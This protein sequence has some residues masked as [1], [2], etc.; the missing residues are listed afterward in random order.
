MK[1]TIFFFVICFSVLSASAQ[2]FYHGAGLGAVVSKPGVGSI[3]AKVFATLHYYPQVSFFE[4]ETFSVSVGIPFTVGFSGSYNGSVGRRID[5]QKDNTLFG[6]VQI[7]LMLNFNN[8][9]G[10]SKDNEQAYGYFF[11][12][13]FGYHSTG[14]D[15]VLVTDELG[16]EIGTKKIYSKGFAPTANAGAR[17]L[18]GS[19]GR[20]IEIRVFYMKGLK[21][22]KPSMF[23]ANAAFNF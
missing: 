9:A 13:G 16:N 23:G 3:E 18:V 10:S 8:G 1:N 5:S 11:G 19:S 6:L 7:P 12:G 22:W 15:A 2:R 14:I 4:A 20:N 17:F 21:D